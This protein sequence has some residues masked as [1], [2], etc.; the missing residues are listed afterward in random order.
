MCR[1]TVEIHSATAEIRQGEKK[2]EEED[3]RR[4]HWAKKYNGLPYSIERLL[5]CVH[6]MHV[7]CV[8]L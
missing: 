8:V 4:N 1:S 5:L 2:K 3:R 7:Y 6:C